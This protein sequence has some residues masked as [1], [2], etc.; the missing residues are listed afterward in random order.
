MIYANNDMLESSVQDDTS[1]VHTNLLLEISLRVQS[2]S[3]RSEQLLVGLRTTLFGKCIEVLQLLE[4]AS[5][6]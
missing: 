6:R 5:T 3:W 2:S 1:I 4:A